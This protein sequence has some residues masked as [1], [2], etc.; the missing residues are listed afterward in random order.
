LI[1]S[2]DRSSQFNPGDVGTAAVPLANRVGATN[3]LS[4][5]RRFPVFPGHL[6]F[7]FGGQLDQ[8]LFILL[9][10]LAALAIA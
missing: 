8:G 4:K 10:L 3:L 1:P 5:D 2:V 9:I 7:Q 6:F